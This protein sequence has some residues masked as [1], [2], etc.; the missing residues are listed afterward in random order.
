MARDI[1]LCPEELRQIITGQIHFRKCPECQGKGETWYIEYTLPERP[2]DSLFKD[3]TEDEFTNFSLDDHPNWDWAEALSQEC[4]TCNTVGY[5][6][7]EL[8]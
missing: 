7:N 8:Y 2:H 3:I 5:V 1:S 4:E 6:S